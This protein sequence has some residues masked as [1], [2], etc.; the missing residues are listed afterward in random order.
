MQSSPRD[1][2]Q[3]TTTATQRAQRATT[4]LFHQLTLLFG[5][6]TLPAALLARRAGVVIPLHRLLERA[7][8]AYD[9]HVDD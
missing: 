1:W 7:N 6:F 3:M 2:Y 4:F 5:L 9:N 8:T